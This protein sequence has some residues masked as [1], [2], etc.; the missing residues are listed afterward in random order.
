MSDI[1][2]QTFSG[3]VKVSNDLTVTTNVHADYFKGNGSLL[4]NLPSGSGGVWNTNSDNEIYFI[5]SNVGISNADPGHN[6]SVGSNLY[7]DDDG[8]NVLVVTGNVKADYFV[9]DGRL[10]T[11]LSGSGGV[12]QTNADN[13]IYFISSNVGISNADPGH[14]LSVGSNLYVDDDGSNVLVVTGNVKA[15]YF[16]GD[17]SLLTNLPSGSGG[18]WNTNAENE[19]YFINNNV[20]IANTNPGHD[21]SVGSNLF[22]DD[23]GINVLV[24]DGNVAAESM[25]IGGI[26][27]IPSYPLSSVTDTGNVTPHTIEFT[28]ATTGLVVSSNIVVAGNV[29]ASSFLGDGSGL[30]ALNAT[31]VTTGTLAAARI[32]TLNQSTT[33]TAATLTTPRSIGGVNFN[34]SVDIVPTTFGAATFSG[35][36]TID[37]DT[38]KID[39]TN[40]RVGIGT[41]DPSNSLHM[42]KAADEATSGLFI[43]KASG[44]VGTAAALL[45]GTSAP[46][47]ANNVGIAKGGIFFERTATNGRGDLQFCVDNVDNTT[48]IALSHSKMTIQSDGNVGIGTT[49]PDAKLHVKGDII[50]RPISKTRTI[51]KGTSG[52]GQVETF[53]LAEDENRILL[54]NHQGS[55][56]SS[57]DYTTNFTAG[58]PTAIGTI[59]HLEMNSSRT[60]NSASGV[61]HKTRIQFNGVDVLSTGN[62]YLSSNGGA[63]QDSYQRNLKRIIILTTDGWVDYSLYPKI[64]MPVTDDAI[65]FSTTNNSQQTSTGSN[66]PLTE[67]M[68]IDGS[69]RIKYNAQPRFSAYSTNGNTTYSGFSAPVVLNKTFY[70]VGS[71]YSTSTGA[72]TAPVSGHYR[73]SFVTYLTGGNTQLSLWYRSSN[74]GNFDDVGPYKL[75]GGS[76]G[77]DE[78]IFTSLLNTT[79]TCTFDVYVPANYQITFGG[80]GAPSI[81]IYRAHS[82]F[83][84]ELIS[85]A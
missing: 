73:F 31:N 67:K 28:N 10:L 78:T 84:G 43:E 22:V 16:S 9:G 23:D 72:F 21:L 44:G 17:G 55:A 35:D 11:G 83:S 33:G 47:E 64:S 13:E 29:T 62:N 7:V 81:T 36:V 61:N 14:N 56:G 66:N 6:L 30:T 38:L 51:T 27:I 41:T 46:S 59:I 74:S 32:P 50:G 34:G 20:G 58:V 15:D 45:F 48:P 2:I 19:I 3:K 52:S 1:N 77:G 65:V 53:T 68:R 80:R 85:A 71:C 5:S 69:G 25:I 40:N 18:V 82:Y 54:N 49:S 60:N 76:A 63:N 37:T 26:S 39:S 12:W 42:Y 57:R 24:V 75:L 70:N 8:S 79:G 4:T